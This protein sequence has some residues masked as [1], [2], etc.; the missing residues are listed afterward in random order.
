MDR[1]DTMTTTEILPMC[2]YC[3]ETAEEI[4][5]GGLALHRNGLTLHVWRA[6]LPP[7]ICG[8]ELADGGRCDRPSLHGGDHDERTER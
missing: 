6:E 5:N 1:K 4:T 2:P 3:E 8:M 7:I